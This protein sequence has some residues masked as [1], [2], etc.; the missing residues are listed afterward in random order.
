[1]QYRLLGK[2]EVERNGELVDIGS[3]RQRAA[4]AFLLKTPNTIVSTDQIIDAV[5][6]DDAA[7][8]RQN[9][10]WV[11]ISGLRTALEP[12]RER[13]TE[14]SVLLTRSPGYL[15]Q[16]NPDEIDTVHFERLVAEG[17]AL[18]DADPAA[19]SLALG[20]ALALWRGRAYEDFAY[21]DFAASEIARL[22]ELRLE[23]VEARIDADLRR[24]MSRELVSEL[25]SLV[26]EHPLRERL[27]GQAMLALYRSGRQAEALRSYQF[28]KAR[29]GDE[30]G[31][32]P[33][34]QIR[35]LEEQIVV[36]DPELEP[37]TTLHLPGTGPEPGLAVRGYEL[38][39]KL[40]EG[41]FGVV[42]RAYQPVVGREVAIKV[43]RP[44][45][46]ND[47]VFIRRFEGEAQLVARLEHPHIVPLYDYWREPGAAY[48]VLR[49]MGR[50]SLRDVV[51]STALSSDEAVRIVQQIAG[52]LETAHRSGVAHGDIKPENILL[53]GE[54]NAF[55]SDFAIAVG[56]RRHSGTDAGGA[57]E[58][59]YAAPEHVA[60]GGAS[61]A[62][63]IYSLG[64]VLAQALTGLEGELAQI[65]GALPQ[66]LAQVIDQATDADPR[67]RYA[68][69]GAFA[70]AVVEELAGADHVAPEEAA[71]LVEAENPYN[72]LRPFS[73]VD[74]SRFYGRGRVID[75]LVTRLGEPGSRGRFVAVVGPSGSGKSS[76]VRA[77]LL[78][79]LS[80]GA[81]PS[82]DMWFVAELTPAPHPFEELDNALTGIAVDPSTT[83]LEQL[84][85]EPTGLRRAVRQLL[86]EG[87]QLLL[88]IDQFEELFTQVDQETADRFI[89]SLVD[90][91]TG[92]HSNI[93]IVVTLRADFYD[94]PLRH[95]T[96]GE[97][98]R[99]GTEVITPM[100]P[101]ELE[102]AI[103]APA[104]AV[105]VTFEP[106]VVAELIR[107]VADRIGA[108][109]L[110][111]YTLTELF[112]GRSSAAIPLSDYQAVGGISGA[113]VRRAEGLLAGLGS[114]AQD[115]TRQLF[116]RLVTL[117]E[118]TEDTRRRVLLAE[119]RD[120][121]VDP[122][123]LDQVLDTFGRHRMISFDR[124][125]ITR[126]PTAEISHEALLIQWTRLHNWIDGAR[127]DVRN[128]R[129]LAQAMAEWQGVNRA[130]DYLLRGGRL[131]QLSG[132]AATTSVPLSV[133]EREFLTASLEERD[134][135][136][137]EQREREERAA[138]AERS[139][140]QR[141]RLL[142][143]VGG[144][145]VIVALLAVFAFVQRQAARDSEAEAVAAEAEAIVARDRA[146]AAEEEARAAEDEARAAEA[147]VEQSRRSLALASEANRSLDED[148]ALSL[149]LAIEA[150]RAT[151]SS[152][153]AT[154]EAVDSLH[155]ALHANGV[156]YPADASTPVAV[157]GGPQGVTG[158]FALPP[159]ELTAVAAA[160]TERTFSEADCLRFFPGEPC[161]DPSVPL[162]AGLGIFGGDEA[163]GV[164]ANGPGALDG[165]SVSLAAPFD[166]S[167]QDKGLVGELERFE[168]QSG[169]S[170]SFIPTATE[171]EISRRRADGDPL[172]DL[173]V[174][175]Q[176]GALVTG[177]GD[178][179]VLALSS[180]LN[181]D[182][183]HA[184]YGEYLSSL[185]TVGVD[186]EWPAAT[187][188]LYGVPV[189]VDVKGLVYYPRA[190]FERAGYSEPET[191]D[192]L[193]ALSRQ[194]VEDGTTPWCVAFESE[195][196][197]GWPGTDWI[198]S[199]VLR[200]NNDLSVY[201]DWSLHRIAFND[202]RVT[203][204]TEL[205]DDVMSTPGF[206]R[207]GRGA[208]SRLNFIVHGL[209]PML[210]D[211][212]ECWFH[213]QAD[214]MLSTV[215]VDTEL[216]SELDF[217]VLPPVDPDRPTPISGGGGVLGVMADRPE[218]RAFVQYA[219][220][221]EWGEVWAADATA[222]FLS[223]SLLFDVS[224]YGT[225]ANESERAARVAL[226]TVARDAIAAGV[227]RFD[228]SDLMPAEIGAATSEGA[229]A[230]W[231][232]MLDYVDG[233]RTM[234]QVLSD[235]DAAWVALEEA[236]GG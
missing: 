171:A 157:R 193:M 184:T 9:A 185:V 214:F 183:L 96:L 174:W 124:D 23:A 123:D 25:E 60:D 31:I 140:K 59:P 201:E 229:G 215:P 222:N 84:A 118:G 20:E 163:Y 159:S 81:L 66:G 100:S 47:P 29:L 120:L 62:G 170:V 236:D 106:A 176:P 38:R 234:G 224:A 235:I 83:L 135:V 218:V 209:L 151:A 5:W 95:R 97:L 13:R 217:F 105:G 152:G 7:A 119:L 208:I 199:L 74:A 11:H 178:G 125:P 103:T 146:V 67:A 37:A 197:S 150:A 202:P 232:G 86:P 175:P 108:L 104:G 98:L 142:S 69:P 18:L 210:G 200:A 166:T 221:P 162:P 139:A 70:D 75:R 6:G 190:A 26:R 138:E 187:G 121:P 133:P 54:G 48:L 17:R 72:G 206:I 53:D 191:W 39:E 212:P 21:E 137:R 19:A 15:L 82:S 87:S 3:F 10:L 143:V 141:L 43:I 167:D 55:L 14:G 12:D 155:W 102:R 165:T 77:G 63:D 93:R 61:P 156:V 129:R 196:A 158:V 89:D 51:E 57:A 161:P 186:G 127:H 172:P 99:E 179:Y 126:G 94:R 136:E 110:L 164:T 188:E 112:D 113:L 203:A 169:V 76:V 181:Q 195:V 225:E 211:Q 182:D 58:P 168:E 24:G 68:Y 132:W 220:S 149:L 50:G 192:E 153:F 90:A 64:V 216:G 49:L 130:D 52:A 27:T 42:Y 154:P 80:K 114:Q 147:T 128:Q 65:R 78:P 2:F 180:Y 144:A 219:A 4:L 8:D 46:A 36:G 160:A 28:L 226:G 189:D 231:R 85:S 228:A 227:W 131:D 233:V 1:M 41:A 148:P 92:E 109:P 88:V 107:E 194:M 230:F 122:Q 213:H 40:G 145:A 30:L 56:G 111:Q 205:V 173:G 223:P 33:S 116:L 207:G 22:E 16:V 34:A 101:E 71:A 91:V 35:K 134:R 73:Q 117:G 115:A 79:A 204:A 198:E 177:A 44:E 32:E 45:L